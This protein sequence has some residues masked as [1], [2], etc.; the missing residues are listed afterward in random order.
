MLQNDGNGIRATSLCKSYGEKAVLKDLS[1]YIEQGSKTLITGDSGCGKT[2]LLRIICGLEKADSGQISGVLKNEISYLFQ[3][4]RLLPWL[5]CEENVRLVIKDKDSALRAAQLL[6]E[7]GIGSETDRRAYPRELSGGMKRRV[8][9]ARALAYE[10]RVLI[11]DEAMRGLDENTVKQTAQ[12]IEK[13]RNGRTV[14]SVAHFLSPLEE[15]ADKILS[16]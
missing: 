5:T 13:Y 1:F 7:L 16:L 8:A 3:E 11:L 6:D 12:V 14:I 2:T 15:N 4:D 10:S 9:I